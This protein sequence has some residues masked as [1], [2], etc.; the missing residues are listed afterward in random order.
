MDVKSEIIRMA[1]DARASGGI[2]SRMSSQVKDRALLDM[3]DELVKQ[4]QMLI[5]ENGKD[6]AYAR[7][8]GTLSRNDGPPDT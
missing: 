4:K 2:L 3:A 6:L 7:D 8:P 1:Q 5:E